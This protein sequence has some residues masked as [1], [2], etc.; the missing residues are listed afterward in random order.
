[1]S[2]EKKHRQLPLWSPLI[3]TA[4]IVAIAALGALSV[5]QH[6]QIKK[7]QQINSRIAVV[8]A[9]GTSQLVNLH[10]DFNRR[11]AKTR[12]TVDELA[13]QY[14]GS[15]KVVEEM[16]GG[17]CLI[18]GEYMFVDPK[19][20]LPLCYMDQTYSNDSGFGNVELRGDVVANETDK[21]YPISVDGKGAPMLAQFTGT[22]FLI[23]KRGFVVTNSH[24]T[25]PWKHAPQYQHVIQAGY[26]PRLL[27]FRA[28]FPDRQNWFSLKVAGLSPHDD[29]AILRCDIGDADLKPLPCQQD[30]KGLKAGQTVVILGY[31]TGFDLLLAR[32]SPERL[33]R[34]IGD[35]GITFEQLALNMARDGLIAPTA[36]RGM[37]GRISDD[38]IAYDAPTTIGASGAPVINTFGKVVAINTSLLK[39]F[40]GTNFGIPISCALELLAEIAQSD[41]PQTD[42]NLASNTT[43]K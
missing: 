9:Q 35:G 39:G 21:I 33:D 23:D 10:S 11:I 14:Q 31:P 38:K 7:L 5:R 22:G 13:S 36:T 27:M 6:L 18:Q 17:V 30:S 41:H 4:F 25:T 8:H 1:M 15:Q 16:A 3:I 42:S 26:E 29:V 20:D 19:T 2:A 37:C 34:I 24:V 43:G 28:Y 12:Q 32:M 40:G